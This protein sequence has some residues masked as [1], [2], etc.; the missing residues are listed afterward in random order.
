[1]GK[2]KAAMFLLIAATLILT[3]CQ[4]PSAGSVKE[5]NAPAGKG[6]ALSTSL[7]GTG[8]LD[9][10]KVTEL[11]GT[12]TDIDS[13]LKNADLTVFNVWEPSCEPCKDELKAFAV[14]SR[15]YAGKGVQIVGII[16]GVT[17]APNEN[18]Q[19]VMKKANVN[20][21]QLLDSKEL[22]SRLPDL[23]KEAP[24]TLFINKDNEILTSVYKGANN[25]AFWESEID[26]YNTQ[27]CKS[28]DL[29]NCA[30]G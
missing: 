22:D 3:A 4:S 27:A 5:K 19:S 1:M 9:N 14:L 26:K 28:N 15:Q 7:K 6:N 16:K 21:L 17:A 29:D 10:F 25:K 12:Q 18:A 2:Q 23:L 24:S 13:I 20:Y 11:D 30:V 8:T